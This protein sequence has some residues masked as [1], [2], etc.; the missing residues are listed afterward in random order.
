M[1]NAPLGQCLQHCILTHI[2]MFSITI[3]HIILRE[4][5]FLLPLFTP[6]NQWHVNLT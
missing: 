6:Q 5:L 4:L 2:E 1:L 3:F